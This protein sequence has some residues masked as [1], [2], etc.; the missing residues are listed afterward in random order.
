MYHPAPTK[1]DI[2]DHTAHNMR[3]VP[4]G[5]Y[6]A[7]VVD[8]RQQVSAPKEM[9]YCELC[10]KLFCRE[11]RVD[12]ITDAD[13]K[14]VRRRVGDIHCPRCKALPVVDDMA[15]VNL[16]T[17][18]QRDVAVIDEYVQEKR[19]FR[20]RGAPAQAKKLHRASRAQ[21]KTRWA[22]WREPLIALF[23]LKGK[24]TSAQ[25]GEVMGYHK[26]SLAVARARHS[27]LPIIIVGQ[28]VREKGRGRIPAL[29]ALDT[30][31]TV[32]LSV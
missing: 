10:T 19:K 8:K 21:G 13:G 3:L 12:L 6:D 25:V 16:L 23:Q 32:V 18:K 15:A 9:K 2:H 17:V 11:F 26:G 7:P 14:Q 4:G 1:I 28:S 22:K 20:R 5:A 24:L 29:Y 30:K 27:G 31:E